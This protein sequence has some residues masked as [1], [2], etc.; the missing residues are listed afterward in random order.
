MSNI[1]N[2][3]HITSFI[4]LSYLSLINCIIEFPLTYKNI[5]GASKKNI[6]KPKKSYSEPSNSFRLLETISYEEGPLTLNDHYYFLA[7]VTIGSNN[8][9][10]NLILETGSNFLW[11]VQGRT[12]SS[13]I[14]VSRSYNPS[15]SKSS[16]NT[17]EPF[18]IN[19]GSSGTVSGTYYTDN[20]KFMDNKIFSM[21]F[22]AANRISISGN[23]YGNADGV[24]GLGHYYE[25]EQLSFMHMLKQYN[26]TDSKIFSIK[27]DNDVDIKEGATGKLYIGK[28]EDF[29]SNNTVTCPL[30]KNNE[31]SD[32]YWNF[33]LDGIS[34]KQSNKEIN[35]S[36]SINVILE[37][38]TNVLILPYEYL[39]DIE[40][41]LKDMNCESYRESIFSSYYEIRCSGEIDTLPDFRL[42]INGTILTIPAKYAFEL[43]EVNYYSNVYFTRSEELYIIGS[44]LYLLIIL[45]L[46][47]I[48]NNYIFIL[49]L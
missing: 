22:G 49:I 30:I 45:F 23:S 5:K 1:K 24:I 2:K 4:L 17:G 37:T 10:F 48:M 46:I 36:R 27:L 29:F 40:K 15:S 31:E 12:R 16:K 43:S 41:D 13:S 34:L 9:K 28:H 7:P 38:A 35:S 8:E 33:Q 26:I 14:R 25:D 6:I 42:N 19:Y 21:K 47:V 11:V 44:P 3:I 32:V 20:F 18:Q 39:T